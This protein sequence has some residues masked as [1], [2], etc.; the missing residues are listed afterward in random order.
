M[1]SVLNLKD[2]PYGRLTVQEL[3]PHTKGKPRKWRCLCSCGNTKDIDQQSL[4]SGAT[5]SCGC[6]RKERAKENIRYDRALHKSSGN[7]K[8]GKCGTPEWHAW[9]DMR[10][11]CTDPARKAWKDYGGRGI[12]VCAAWIDSFE[13]FLA[14]MGERPSDQHSLGRRDNDK[15]YSPENCRWETKEE[16]ARNRRSS[17]FYTVG[18]RTLT[19]AAWCK[20]LG[21]KRSTLDAKLAKDPDYILRAL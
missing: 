11:R 16:Q 3:A 1:A 20:E 19:I 10:R 21:M 17:R 9:I 6:L 5:L 14:D 4:T 15:G 18:D 2:K 7:L 8:H 13:M 12:L